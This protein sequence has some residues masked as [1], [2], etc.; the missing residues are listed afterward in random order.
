[1]YM[2]PELQD[3][4]L[5]RLVANLEERAKAEPANV[6]TL[7]QLARTHAMAYARKVGDADSVKAWS[8][9]RGKDP[10]QPWFGFE[11]PHVPYN[12]VTQAADAKKMEVAKAHLAKAIEVYRKLSLI[13][14]SEPTRPY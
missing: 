12:N 13:H 2:R 8:G 10:V 7:H 4:P 9:N 1:M 14:I 5:E 3:L 11:A 6:D